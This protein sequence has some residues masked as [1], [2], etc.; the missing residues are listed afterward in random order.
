MSQRFGRLIGSY[1]YMLEGVF[2]HGVKID[3]FEQEYG[4][5]KMVGLMIVSDAYHGCFHVFV[6]VRIGAAVGSICYLHAGNMVFG[7]PSCGKCSLCSLDLPDGRPFNVELKRHSNAINIAERLGLPNIVV[8]N[9]RELNGTASAEINEELHRNLVVSEC[10]IRVHATSQRY[11]KIQEISEGG[12]VARS[13]LHKKVRQ[14]RAS[15]VLVSKAD[16][17]LLQPKMAS[18]SSQST[19]K[20]SDAALVSET[21]VKNHERSSKVVKVG[22]LVHVSKFNKNEAGLKVDFLKKRYWFN[23]GI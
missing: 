21:N 12:R 20:E 2:G 6:T 5:I 7:S 3:A 15:P 13:L 10:R 8:G 22:D 16:D 17:S 11:I 18:F 23:S 14:S 9:A 4:V 1:R 19:P